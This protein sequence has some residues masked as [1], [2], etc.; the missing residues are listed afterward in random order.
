MRKLKRGVVWG[1]WGFITL[2]VLVGWLIY[3]SPKPPLVGLKMAREALAAAQKSE[4]EVYAREAYAVAEQAYDS[5][6]VCWSTENKRFFLVRDYSQ[7][8][9]WIALVIEKAM[10]AEQLSGDRSKSTNKRVR[11]GL[12]ALERKVNRYERYFKRMPLPSSVV[13]AHN[14]GVLKLSEAKFAW[15]NKR[16]S[17]AEKHYQMAT[18][19]INNS[20]EKAEV[21]VRQWFSGH[22]NWQKQAKQAVQMSKNGQKVILVDKLGHTCMVYQNGRVISSFEA[23]LG[24]NWMGDKQRKGDKATPEGIYRV[25]RKKDTA[26]TK[27]YKALLINYPNDDDRQ[28]FALAKKNGIL[29]AKTDIGGLI[30]IHGLGG[31][32]VDWTDGCVAL[33]N[34]DMDSLFRQVGVGTT[35]V[36]VG[37]LKPLSEVLGHD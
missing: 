15:Q 32:G 6:M 24:V 4:A 2:L 20:N 23:E 34:K 17:E 28:R 30:E 22:A 3:Q 27:F 25:T 16:F 18:E 31:K 29:S 37:S 7:L 14:K 10:E 13:K 5:A 33:K 12:D 11:A 8:D 9:A 36:I 21:I 1:F 35:V 26:N 19:L